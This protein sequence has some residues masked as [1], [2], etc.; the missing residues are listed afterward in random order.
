MSPLTKDQKLAML[1]VP[2]VLFGVLGVSYASAHD[3]ELTEEQ[4]RA[5]EVAYDLR[6]HGDYEGARSLIQKI[7]IPDSGTSEVSS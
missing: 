3:L 2:F 1:A 6:E 7:D 5:L 4:Q